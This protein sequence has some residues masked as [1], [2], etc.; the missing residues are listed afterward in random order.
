M[1]SKTRVRFSPLLVALCIAGWVPTATWAEPNMAEG[2]WEITMKMEAAEMPFAMPPQ[3][4]NRCLTKKDVVPDMSQPGQNCKMQD[5][6]VT[7]D[8]VTWRMQCEGPQGAMDAEG[9]VKYSGKTYDGTMTAKVIQ[10]GAPPMNMKYTF[11]GRHTG[12]CRAE[13]SKKKAGDY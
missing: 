11:Q 8:T 2:N 3:T 9:R 5:R 4:L 12:P 6:K 10:A 7:G 13:A 1:N